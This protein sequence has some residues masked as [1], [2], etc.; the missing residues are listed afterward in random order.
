[1]DRPYKFFVVA[2][3]LVN[4]FVLAQRND[5]VLFQ[6]VAGTSEVLPTDSPTPD[7][8]ASPTVEPSPIDTPFPTPTDTPAPSPTDS[9]SP[10]FEPS[11]TY[12]PPPSSTITFAPVP[13][14][15]PATW[16]DWLNENFETIGYIN[17]GL[18]LENSYNIGLASYRGWQYGLELTKPLDD[19]SRRLLAVYMTDIELAFDEW[20]YHEY[21]VATVAF[22]KAID[23][24][25]AFLRYAT[26]A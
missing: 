16:T 15:T 7:P 13:Y 18:R 4:L 17:D 26:N 22:N 8:S 25:N 20:S 11:P 12:S 9:P 5:S 23:E 21:D 2:M 1:M 6:A 3:L 10:S 19:T 24:W 14:P